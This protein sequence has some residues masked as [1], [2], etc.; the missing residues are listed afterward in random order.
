MRLTLQQLARALGG[1]VSGRSVLAPG[2]GHSRRDR[3]MQVTLSATA[4]NGYIVHSHAG[5]GWQDCRKYIDRHFGFPAFRYERRQRPASRQAYF[6]RKVSAD[7]N[8][9]KQELALTIWREAIDPRGTLVE[10]YLRNR[11]L[12]L[13]DEASEVIRF[14][15]ACPF[16]SER[17]PAMVALI[18]NIATDAPQ[19]IQ[20]TALAA[21]GRAIKRDGKTF[22]MT[23]GPA[24]E[25][26]VKIDPDEDVTQGLTI[27]EGVETCLTARQKGL[28]PAWACLG[29]AGLANFPVL[30]GVEGLHIL[31]ENDSNG[32]SRRAVARCAHRWNLAGRKVLFVEPEREFDDINGELRGAS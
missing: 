16:G 1:E 24:R 12:Q 23:L 4:W 27:G 15:P 25:G 30:A 19:G 13:P 9:G 26:A 21:D 8:A 6:S 18:R 17:L 29:T 32:A 7:S 2:P 31:C 22:R 5:D 10:A 14:Q 28:R 11:G 20:R 3:S